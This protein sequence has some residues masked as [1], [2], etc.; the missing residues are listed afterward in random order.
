MEII[1]LLCER[2]G[3]LLF[4]FNPGI[5]AKCLLMVLRPLARPTLV[6]QAGTTLVQEIALHR[7][8]NDYNP[9]L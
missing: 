6:R 3:Q 7:I 5:V 1:E 4:G 8:V 2:N 9:P